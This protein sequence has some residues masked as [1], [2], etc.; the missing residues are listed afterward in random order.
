MHGVGKKQRCCENTEY[1]PQR[2]RQKNNVF[3]L[4]AILILAWLGLRFISDNLALTLWLVFSVAVIGAITFLAI[5]L[6]KDRERRRA[7]KIAS[8]IVDQHLEDLC[9]NRMRI[10]RQDGFGK[11]LLDKW[12]DKID[13]FIKEYIR[14][15]LTAKQQPIMDAARQEI[16]QII[17]SATKSWIQRNPLCASFSDSMTGEGFEEFCAEQLRMNGWTAHL[18][19]ASGDQG[20]DVIAEKRGVR[21]VLQCKKYSGTVGNNAVQE[22]VAGKAYERAHHCAVV[23]N[24]RYTPAAEQLAAANG[25]L[26]LHYSDL[27]RLGRLLG[28]EEAVTSASLNSSHSG[29]VPESITA[30]HARMQIAGAAVF[31]DDEA[32]PASMRRTW[33]VVSGA[34]ALIVIAASVLFFHNGYPVATRYTSYSNI[35]FGY[36]IDFP[37]SFVARYAAFDNDGMEFMSPD[38]ATSLTLAAGNNDSQRSTKQFYDE[39]IASGKGTLGYHRLGGSWFVVTWDNEDELVY[40]KMFVGRG[41]Y[42]WFKLVFPTKQ[43]SVY[44]P[45]VTAMEKSFKPGLINQAR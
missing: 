22:I 18:T 23:S 29:D 24:S 30:S 5:L 40:E 26:L 15:A 34:A 27:S 42:N 16:R 3:G 25:V 8:N 4:I 21:V 38:G 14:P 32:E 17:D 20:V 19:R 13:Y 28:L 9:R 11:E 2:K 35:R 6:L 1:M 43:R 45:I 33:F 12:Y 39:A 10:V 37:A 31:V 7:L 44:E 36:R 41:S